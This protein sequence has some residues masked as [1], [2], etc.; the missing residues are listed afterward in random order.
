MSGKKRSYIS[1]ESSD[2]DDDK[3][4]SK[5]YSNKEKVNLFERENK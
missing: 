4:N 2:D 1:S 5:N 3:E